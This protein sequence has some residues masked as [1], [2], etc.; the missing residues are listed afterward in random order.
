MVIIHCE[1]AVDSMHHVVMLVK[2]VNS[3]FTSKQ[4]YN[5]AIHRDNVVCSQVLSHHHKTFQ[6]IWGRIAVVNSL[7]YNHGHAASRRLK[8]RKPQV[9]SSH[10]WAGDLVD[11]QVVLVRSQVVNTNPSDSRVYVQHSPTAAMLLTSFLLNYAPNIPELNTL[12]AKFRKSYSWVH[13][14]ES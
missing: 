10:E 7:Y 9:K 1:L 5:N 8:S 13:G 14:C 6:T 4:H 3:Q 12:I 11:F 2:I